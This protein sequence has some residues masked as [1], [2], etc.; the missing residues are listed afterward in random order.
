LVGARIGRRTRANC[1]NDPH[2]ETQVEGTNSCNVRYAAADGKGGNLAHTDSVSIAT[3][4]FTSATDLYSDIFPDSDR[5]SDFNVDANSH[6]DSIGDFA[7]DSGANAACNGNSDA[8]TDT[9]SKIDIDARAN[10]NRHAADSEINRAVA[11]RGAA[12][13]KLA[14][15]RDR[16]KADE[17]FTGVESSGIITARRD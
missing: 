7:S 11:E 14:L 10:T 15:G 8:H 6:S 4:L 9:N 17:S 1:N 13:K 2:T 12:C 16:G 3:G 5:H